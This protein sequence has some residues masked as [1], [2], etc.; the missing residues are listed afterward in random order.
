MPGHAAENG[1]TSEDKA[2]RACIEAL[3]DHG[4]RGRYGRQSFKA[5]TAEETSAGRRFS[6]PQR[7]IVGRPDTTAA[8]RYRDGRVTALTING[9]TV[10]E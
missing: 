5:V 4:V 7:T 2:R 1:R 6:W 10:T 8:C 3:V 9:Q